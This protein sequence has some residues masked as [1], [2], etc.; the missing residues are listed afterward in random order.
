MN[1]KTK[2]PTNPQ[3]QNHNEQ[4]SSDTEPLASGSGLLDTE[5][6]E[7][8]WDLWDRVLKRIQKRGAPINLSR[9]LLR[10]EIPDP[11][12]GKIWFLLVADNETDSLIQLFP[13]LLLCELPQQVSDLISIDIQRTFP[14]HD[15]FKEEAGLGQSSLFRISKAYAAYDQ[16]IGYCQGMSFIAAVLLLHMPE[17][18]A[19]GVMVKIMYDYGVRELYRAEMKALK[20]KLYQLERLL[21][22]TLPDLAAHLRREQIETHMYGSQWFL[23]L[24]SSKFP[25]PFV[26]RLFDIFLNEGLDFLLRVSLSLLKDNRSAFI[27]ASFEEILQFFRVNLPKKYNEVP[28][29]GFMKVLDETQI[30]TRLLQRYEKDFRQKDLS[31]T[32]SPSTQL[33]APSSSSPS[34]EVGEEVKTSTLTRL[35]AE[36]TRLQKDNEA[37][38]KRLTQQD[39]ELSKLADEL[40]QKQVAHMFNLETVQAQASALSAQ[41]HSVKTLLTHETSRSSSLQER[42]LALESSFRAS[43]DAI[44]MD[45][46]RESRERKALEKDVERLLAQVQR[47]S[48]QLSE[49]MDQKDQLQR[50][51]DLGQSQSQGKSGPGRP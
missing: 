1:H 20:L 44:L 26:Y 47:L 23:T 12:R 36:N 25:Q 14:G 42:L 33:P 3:S 17:E 2:T 35:E 38:R 29:S 40:V 39:Q 7:K 30:S 43:L 32:T 51:I 49:V 24:F 46:E 41:N 9:L 45:K 10:R 5:I 19:F 15:M 27:H 6:N 37:L 22:D 31:H 16:E 50:H 13:Q 48:G 4:T 8:S 18:E 28:L 34:S 11:L 21:E